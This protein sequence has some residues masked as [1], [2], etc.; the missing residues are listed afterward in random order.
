[1]SLTFG[2]V[3]KKKVSGDSASYEIQNL[4]TVEGDG[5]TFIAFRCIHSKKTLAHV[6]LNR[7]AKVAP[8]QLEAD[9]PG[10]GGKP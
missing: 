10:A 8:K 5:K 6:M 3:L 1:M 9:L 4:C 7:S 2:D